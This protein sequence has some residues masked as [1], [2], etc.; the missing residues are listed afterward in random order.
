MSGRAFDSAARRFWKRRPAPLVRVVDPPIPDSLSQ[1]M[2]EHGNLTV[3]LVI[4]TDPVLVRLRRDLLDS[5]NLEIELL[6]RF[7]KLERS[8]DAANA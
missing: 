7:A 6:V 2:E 5:L 4:E 8:A 1:L 3:G